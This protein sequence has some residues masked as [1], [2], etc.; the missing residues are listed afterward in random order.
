MSYPHQAYQNIFKYPS[1]DNNTT[2]D[3]HGNDG[4]EKTHLQYGP[5]NGELYKKTNVLSLNEQS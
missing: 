4:T 1:I 5:E 3:Y 2:K